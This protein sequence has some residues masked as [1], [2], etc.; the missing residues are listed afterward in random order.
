MKFKCLFEYSIAVLLTASL[1]VIS[2]GAQEPT[3][4]QPAE[5]Y[6][7]DGDLA[8][9]PLKAPDTSSPRA[10]LESFLDFIDRSYRITQAAHEENTNTPGLFTPEHLWLKGQNAQKLFERGVHCLDLSE[11]PE[12]IKVGVGKGM[13]LRLKEILDRIELPP[14][15]QVPDA[16]AVEEDRETRKFPRFARWRIPNTMIEIARVEDGP[17]KGE[18]LFTPQTVSRLSAG[19]ESVRHLP[20][21]TGVFVTRGFLDFYVKTPGRL[22]PPKWAQWLPVWSTRLFLYQTLWQWCALVLVLLFVGF[23]LRMLHRWFRLRST[24][25]PEAKGLWRRVLWRLIAV[26]FIMLSDYLLDV[27]I[28]FTGSVKIVIRYIGSTI[29]WGLVASSIF[30]AGRA[31]AETI[32]ASPWVDPKG[33]QASYYRALAV[34]VGFI[35]AAAAL[36]YGLSSLGVALTP[37]LAG[38]GI[39]GMAIALAARPT[40]ENIIATFTI[41]ADRPYRV[42]QRVNI[43]G[44]N[45]TIES[46][47]LRSTRI[48]LLTGNQTLIPNEKMAAAEIEN[49]GR[50]PFIRRTFNVTITYDTPPEKVNRAVEILREILALPQGPDPES[51]GSIEEAANAYV[52][53]GEVRLEP[54]PNE[55]INKPDFPP[56]VH[57]NELNADSL[58]I[59]VNYWYHPPNYWD[60]MEHAHRINLQIVERFNAEEIDFAFPTQTLH[61]AGDENRPLDIGVRDLS[62]EQHSSLTKAESRTEASKNQGVDTERTGSA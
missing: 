42:G 55:A 59:S 12:A 36:I 58:N 21:T 29:S 7:L 6:Q 37:L 51:D 39:G 32:I 35:A 43:L 31:I 62:R 40:L 56:R 3:S 28:N 27:Q 61:V 46:I 38:V 9:H 10:T 14:F 1:V 17:R 52:T 26:G 45:G 47:G 49:I 24:S 33:I 13:A 18:Y 30:T 8:R 15:D 44:Q 11:I 57:F 48:R 22:L 41:F 50:R 20:Y 2:A 4:T 16:Q 34:V 5:V 25:L 54:H 60:Y 23:F 53:G 19:Y